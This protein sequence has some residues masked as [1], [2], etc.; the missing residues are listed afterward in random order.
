MATILVVDDDDETRESIASELEAAGHRVMRAESA[1]AAMRLALREPPSLVVMDLVL[2]DFH[3]IEAAGAI[4]AV[5]G[6]S[7]VPIVVVTSESRAARELDPG[8]FGAV[9]VLMKPVPHAEL[10]EAVRAG[11]DGRA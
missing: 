10:L 1:T 8:S 3:G 5:A 11:L 9:A 7:G 4:R 6:T 2:P